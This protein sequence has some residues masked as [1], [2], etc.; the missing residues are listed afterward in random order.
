MEEPRADSCKCTCGSI[1][2]CGGGDTTC[3]ALEEKRIKKQ[4]ERLKRVALF[5]SLLAGT[6]FRSKGFIL[7]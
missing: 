7:P 5:V 1:R 3:D 2:I 6:C 4:K